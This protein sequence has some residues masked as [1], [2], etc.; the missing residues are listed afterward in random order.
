[1]LSTDAIE[2]N[3]TR[4]TLLNLVLDILNQSIYRNP[5][6]LVKKV[7]FKNYLNLNI[8]MD[9]EL[10]ADENGFWPLYQLLPFS[11]TLSTKLTLEILKRVKSLPLKL[12]KLI[13]KSIRE[14][15]ISTEI[16]KNLDLL[17][18]N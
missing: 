12:I 1:M 8:E 9:K 4:Q 16:Y 14:D 3:K 17:S 2:I 15:K 7:P 18:Q 5:D 10:E 13:V 11:L 6:F